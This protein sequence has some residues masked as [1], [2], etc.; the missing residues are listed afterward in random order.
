MTS[1]RSAVTVCRST[2]SETPHVAVTLSKERIHFVFHCL[3]FS[4]LSSNN[5]AGFGIC[6][7]LASVLVTPASRWKVW[8][9]LHA[10]VTF[11]S[12]PPVGAATL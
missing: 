7:C 4:P 6:I 5:C 2:L 1:K 10:N 3:A 12:P 8:D 9:P 11:P